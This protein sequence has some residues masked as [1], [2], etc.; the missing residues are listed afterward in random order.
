MSLG[1]T[2]SLQPEPVGDGIGTAA[3]KF[4]MD[5]MCSPAVK[6]WYR[7]QEKNGEFMKV[8]LLEPETLASCRWK[9]WE[10]G[11]ARNYSNSKHLK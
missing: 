11:N 5:Y 3:A 10:T 7:K 1:I 8:P 6:K 4:D 9:N 2:E